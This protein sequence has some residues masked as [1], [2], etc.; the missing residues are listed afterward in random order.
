[1]HLTVSSER[2][3]RRNETRPDNCDA[4]RRRL[5]SCLQALFLERTCVFPQTG[6]VT[7]RSMSARSVA[8][9]AHSLWQPTAVVS[10]AKKH[11]DRRSDADDRRDD[12]D[13]DERERAHQLSQRRDQPQ[14]AIDVV[15]LRVH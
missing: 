3:V 4:T 7:Q 6:T 14:R 10:T 5:S 13:L 12:H 9:A 11:R 2:N 1:M 8:H 15:G